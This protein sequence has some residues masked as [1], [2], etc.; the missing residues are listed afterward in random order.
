MIVTSLLLVRL[1]ADDLTPP[2]EVS[3]RVEFLVTDAAA[4]WRAEALTAALPVGAEVRNDLAQAADAARILPALP[5]RGG[6]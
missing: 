2:V 6:G 3:P 1:L 5:I 4:G